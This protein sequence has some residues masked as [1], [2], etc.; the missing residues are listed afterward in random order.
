M[1]IRAAFVTLAVGIGWFTVTATA[2]QQA[3]LSDF[4]ARPASS[5]RYPEGV[6]SR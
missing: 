2:R 1:K 6:E 4:A 3:P 5:V